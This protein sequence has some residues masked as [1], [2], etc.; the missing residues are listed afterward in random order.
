MKVFEFNEHD[1]CENPILKTLKCL[2]G[3]EAQISVA[4]VKN[5]KWSYAIRFHGKDQGWGQPLIYHAQY[6]VFNT[7]DEAYKEG[8]KL[9]LK[10]VTDNDYKNR[11][12]A[13]IEMLEDE[14]SP[15]VQNQLSLF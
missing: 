1:V 4:I 7:K 6:T 11:Y 14:L 3:Y 10:Q 5:G 15:V 13:I 9:L 2:K 8:V 12:K